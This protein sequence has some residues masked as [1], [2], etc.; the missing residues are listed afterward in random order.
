MGRGFDQV[1]PTRT[2]ARRRLGAYGRVMALSLCNL[3][4]GL[5]FSLYTVRTSIA[6]RLGQND[7]INHMEC[8]QLKVHD[9]DADT[10]YKNYERAR[11]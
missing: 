7:T 3:L 1:G 10:D 2:E 9:S 11:G 6:R 5:V 4:S 8:E